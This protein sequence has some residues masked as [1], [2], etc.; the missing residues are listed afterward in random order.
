MLTEWINR[1]SNDAF[2]NEEYYQDESLFFQDSNDA[3]SFNEL[4][5]NEHQKIISEKNISPKMQVR[6][7]TLNEKDIK[8]KNNFYRIFSKKM[9]FKKEFVQ[10]I[11]N[12]ILVSNL[13]LAKMTRIEFRTIS[14][15]FKNYSKMDVQI[16]NCLKENKELI[17]K[18]ILNLSK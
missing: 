4:L 6:K 9:R 10:K 5:N 18:T 12:S 13:G 11:H 7:V 15:Y 14:I 8:F 1:S 17:E 3:K 2:N 16:I